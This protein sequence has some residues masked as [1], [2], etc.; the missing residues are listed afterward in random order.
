MYGNMDNHIKDLLSKHI[1]N[2]INKDERRE[3]KRFVSHLSDAELGRILKEV[4]MERYR[5]MPALVDFNELIARLQINSPEKKR[6][7]ISFIR[8]AAAV[9][10]IP[11]LIGSLFF[12]YKDNKRLNTFLNQDITVEVKS[13]DKA[14]LFLP[15]GT[16]VF[17]NAATTLTY[18]SHFGFEKR[19]IYVNGEAYLKVV[20][21][22]ELPFYIHTDYIRIEVLGTEFN[23]A[24]YHNIIETTLIE[25][26][27]RLT[28]KG[29]NPQTTTLS[30]NMKA[31]YDKE[32]DKLTVL[33]TTTHFET[34]WL[35]GELVFRSASLAQIMDKL[36]LRYGVEI[37]MA[38]NMDTD[39]FT[40]S[41][42]TNSVYEILNSLRIHYDFTYQT[43]AD[44]KIRILFK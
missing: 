15:D 26:S 4:W 17:L 36:K 12:L 44:H 27:I 13:G 22:P 8:W 41:F 40:G 29:P 30:P 35:R 34:A 16:E 21:N 10:L 28:T 42:S 37:E 6:Q 7:L 33:E 24:S 1:A 18:P 2:D 38:G 11:L 31:I 23:L 3:L 25:G 32:L 9:V 5:E 14:N 19:N 39:L 20:K 43:G